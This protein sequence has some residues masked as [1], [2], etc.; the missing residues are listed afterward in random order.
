MNLRGVG[1]V[2]RSLRCSMFPYMRAHMLL[3]KE[4][5]KK[6]SSPLQLYEKMKSD[7]SERA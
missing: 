2:V 6:N 7:G 1:F 3:V 5:A 4:M